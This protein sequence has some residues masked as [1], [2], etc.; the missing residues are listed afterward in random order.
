MPVLV[1][2]VAHG[3]ARAHVERVLLCQEADL[4][5]VEARAPL[6]VLQLRA[7]VVL[8]VAEREVLHL[9]PGVFVHEF[10]VQ[11]PERRES[12]RPGAGVERD[13]GYPRFCKCPYF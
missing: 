11:V 3:Q 9:A 7:V 1:E 12:V 6:L 13:E 10:H 5:W 4:F 2:D 8:V